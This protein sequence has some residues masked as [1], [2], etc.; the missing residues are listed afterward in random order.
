MLASALDPYFCC[1]HCFS[2]RPVKPLSTKQRL[3]CSANDRYVAPRLRCAA[4]NAYVLNILLAVLCVTDSWPILSP[5]GQWPSMSNFPR[6][7]WRNQ[8]IQNLNVSR[9][10]QS[11]REDVRE[12]FLKYFNIWRLLLLY[13]IMYTFRIQ[14]SSLGHKLKIFSARFG[15]IMIPL[16]FPLR[17]NLG[18]TQ[19]KL[20]N[21]SVSIG[22]RLELLTYL[23][24]VRL[25][26]GFRMSWTT[27][28]IVD[29]EKN[30]DQQQR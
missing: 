15:K 2:K 27:W 13:Y 1:L 4:V 7:F 14:Q 11:S 12:V 20:Q 24:T 10:I 8:S 28:N 16:S 22:V 29:G 25:R 6:T 23:F 3:C 5:A 18:T 26:I 19:H 17:I 9:E 30:Y 21:S